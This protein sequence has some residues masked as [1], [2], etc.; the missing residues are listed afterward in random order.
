VTNGHEWVDRPALRRPRAGLASATVSGDILVL[1]GFSNFT[2]PFLTSVESRV[3]G[4]NGVWKDLPSPMPTGRGNLSAG[5]L[6][7]LV[8]A[9][10]GLGDGDVPLDVVERYDPVRKSWETSTPLPEPRVGPGVV[11]FGGLLYVAGG[12]IPRGR[13]VAAEVSNSVIVYDPGS[14]NWTTVAQMLTRRTRL[15]LVATENHLYAIGGFTQ[16]Y[17][18]LESVERYD[19]GS[20]TWTKVASMN[21]ARGLPGATVTSGKDRIV[22]VGGAATGGPPGI[23]NPHAGALHSTEIYDVQANQWRVHPAQL[24]RGRVSLVCELQSDGAVLAIGGALRNGASEIT[25][26]VEALTVG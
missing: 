5:E 19:P 12:E 25:D 18:G 17:K 11:G 16:A 13:G 15:R 20:N 14:K 9:L 21:E 10:G 2:D 26:H 6:D 22:V 23:R 24:A 1:G 7:G 8:Y 4:G 3:T